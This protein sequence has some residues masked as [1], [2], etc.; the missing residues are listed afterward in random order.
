M[1]VLSN[2]LFLLFI[3][4]SGSS[5]AMQQ[6][7]LA[8][9]PHFFYLEAPE[10]VDEYSLG[11]MYRKHLPRNHGMVFI[12]DPK[13]KIAPIMWMKNTYLSLDMLFIGP[14]SRIKCVFEKTKPLSLDLLHCDE[15]ISAVIELNAGTVAQLNIK[16]GRIIKLL[17]KNTAA[18]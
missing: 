13:N 15:V 6:R 2:L 8:I 17:K 3:F 1:N 4:L 5:L 10:T 16:K 18:R 7:I 9:K 14:D 12:F 11:L